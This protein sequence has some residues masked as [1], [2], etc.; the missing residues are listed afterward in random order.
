[1]IKAV[2]FDMDDT[3][4][5]I[6][7]T[8]FAT[9]FYARE[10][11]ILGHVARKPWIPIGAAIV[12]SYLAVADEGREDDLTN[13]SLFDQTFER[14]TG[15]PLDE[16]AIADALGYYEREIL[17]HMNGTLVNAHPEPGG[18]AAVDK[19]RDLGLT[20]ALAT[21]PSF[22]EAV[23]RCRMRWAGIDGEDFARVSHMG[24]STRVKPSARYY[25]EFCSAIG[26]APYE[27]IMVGNDASRDFPR[28]DCGLVTAYVGHARPKRATWRGSMRNL[29]IDL[30]YLVE[31]LG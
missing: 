3:L 28:P 18:L 31:T 27:C 14:A 9:R 2:L 20:V 15:I 11:R 16:P 7:L 24:N 17:P 23:V 5:D 29:A 1:M 21:N 8:L 30:P 19:A 10:A 12:R 25:E 26:F 22:S 6:N 13:E 4:L